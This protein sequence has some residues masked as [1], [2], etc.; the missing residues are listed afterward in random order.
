MKLSFFRKPVHYVPPQLEGGLQELREKML[1]VLLTTA[2]ILGLIAFIAA[3][4]PVIQS[5]RYGLLGVYLFCY[6]WVLFVALQR[7][8]LSFRIK[9]TSTLFLFYLL[10]V[11][12]LEQHGLNSDAGV[13]FLAFVTMSSLMV[14]IRGGLLALLFSAATYSVAGVFINQGIFTP[15]VLIDNQNTID[16]IS[17]GAVLVMLCGILAF[18]LNTILQGLNASIAKVKILVVDTDR[19]RMQLRRNSQDLQRRLAQLHTITEI[20][21]SISAMLE[22]KEL[23]QNVVDSLSE[24]FNLYFVGIFLLDEKD[25]S[26]QEAPLESEIRS[27]V[28][29]L[30]LNRSSSEVVLQASSSKTIPVGYRMRIGGTPGVGWTAHNRKPRVVDVSGRKDEFIANY[31]PMAHTEL[32]IPLFSHS[33][34][35]GILGI[36]ST[37]TNAFD[38]D[39]ISLF[40]SLADSFATALENARLFQQTQ[41]ALDEIRI[42]QR[43]Y[44]TR[45]WA[46]AEQIHQD[47]SYTFENSSESQIPDAPENEELSS[48]SNSIN[49]RDQKI[50]QIV[51]E[52]DKPGWTNEERYFIESVITEAALAL[53]NARLLDETL[54]RSNH[55]RLITEITRT[56][57]ASTDIE[58]IL[59]TAIRELGRNLGASEA[60]ISLNTAPENDGHEKLGGISQ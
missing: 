35:L 6:G 7:Q 42:L 29:H 20:E 18:S 33:R 49:L 27:E 21:H 36:Y 26:T 37:Q 17:A 24:R 44:L 15:Q 16:W 9:I 30:I 19:D 59:S 2:A 56:V 47:L 11:I 13:F 50:G 5:H 39:D 4:I 23:L 41:N 8:Q 43:Q 40:Q 10:G 58:T 48:Y 12:N 54:R 53:D 46:E 38:A 32:T 14:G 52:T 45:T 55:D 28:E 3:A 25:F 31:L 1:S 60:F 34:A 51:L 57:R 22:P